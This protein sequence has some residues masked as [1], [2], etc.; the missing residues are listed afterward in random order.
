[1]SVENKEERHARMK[2]VGIICTSYT[3][4][5]E[6]MSFLEDQVRCID[7]TFCLFPFD[8]FLSEETA[9]KY[10]IVLIPQWPFI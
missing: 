7:I 3:S 5:H 4:L 9:C 6:H 2:S 10:R 1:M 8:S